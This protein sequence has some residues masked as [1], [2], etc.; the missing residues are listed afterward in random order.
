[1]LNDEE[2]DKLNVKITFI[3]HIKGSIKGKKLFDLYTSEYIAKDPYIKMQFLHMKQDENIDF[4]Y[5]TIH[6]EVTSMVVKSIK[7]KK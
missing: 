6:G 1:M 3:S 5:T 2:A 4:S 7:V